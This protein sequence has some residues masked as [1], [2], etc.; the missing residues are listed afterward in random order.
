LDFDLRFVLVL[1]LVFALVFAFAIAPPALQVFGMIVHTPLHRL[2]PPA[3]AFPDLSACLRS[4][5]PSPW[6]RT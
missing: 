4:Q 1:A 6:Q 2:K 5:S 3:S